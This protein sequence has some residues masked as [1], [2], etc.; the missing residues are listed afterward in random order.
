[1]H[2]PQTKKT[3]FLNHK[4]E[5]HILCFLYRTSKTPLKLRLLK[6]VYLINKIAFLK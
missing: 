4:Q 5:S 6:K 2:N 1:M 3:H